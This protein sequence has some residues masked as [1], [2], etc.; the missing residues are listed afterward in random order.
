[1]VHSTYDQVLPEELVEQLAAEVMR[2][3]RS[4]RV[5]AAI[6][7]VVGAHKAIL[8]E[9]GEWGLQLSPSSKSRRSNTPRPTLR[10]AGE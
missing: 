4:A 8:A 2:T 3:T 1:M 7:R 6:E 5:A 9:L 10:P